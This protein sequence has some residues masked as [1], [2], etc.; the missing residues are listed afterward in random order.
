VAWRGPKKVEDAQRREFGLPEAT[1]PWPQRITERG[2]L[3][4]QAFDE[5][6]YPGW[7]P[8]G[9]NEWA[10]APQKAI[11]RRADDGVAD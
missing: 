3:E 2:W 10:A 9:P 5:V 1:R 11:R 4:I 6:C 7:Q 8:N